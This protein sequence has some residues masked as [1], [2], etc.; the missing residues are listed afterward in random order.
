MVNKKSRGNIT[1][2]VEFITNLTHGQKLDC[3]SYQHN[4]HVRS[5]VVGHLGTLITSLSTCAILE[6]EKGNLKHKTSYL[7]YRNIYV[8][9]ENN[10]YTNRA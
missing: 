6:Q 5:Q 3:L 8:L 2:V 1:M 9:C 7:A 4:Y 10:L